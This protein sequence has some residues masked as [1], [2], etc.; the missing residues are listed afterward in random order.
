MTKFDRDITGKAVSTLLNGLNILIIEDEHIVAL[1]LDDVLVEIGAHSTHICAT[2]H[3][4][5]VQLQV[6]LKEQH[7]DAVILDLKLRDGS[8]LALLPLLRS[9]SLPVIITSGYP[10]MHI[11][12]MPFLQKPYSFD[13]LERALKS[14]LD[15]T[16]RL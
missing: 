6:H 9:L 14:V 2:L 1:G 15:L 12:Q 8:G 10:E 16:Q 5:Q 3:E 7:Y 11:D 13:M 4:A